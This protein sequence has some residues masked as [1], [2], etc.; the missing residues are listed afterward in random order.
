MN[1]DIDKELY[2]KMNLYDKI[3]GACMVNIYNASEDGRIIIKEFNPKNEIHLFEYEVAK[4]ISTVYSNRTIY[5]NMNI[6]KYIIFKVKHRK[7]KIKRISNKKAKDVEN[8]FLRLE[9]VAKAFDSS[10]FVFSDIYNLYWKKRK[11][12]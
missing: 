2:D 6:L 9:F 5:L 12:K 8:F 10:L 11:E 4:M 1:S 3:V 7:N